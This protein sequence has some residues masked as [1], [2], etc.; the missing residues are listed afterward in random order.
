MKSK[1]KKVI[2]PIF[3]IEN[4]HT[5]RIRYPLLQTAKGVVVV[6]VVEEVVE[7]EEEVLLLLSM[8]LLSG[9]CRR[10]RKEGV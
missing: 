4:S 6:V 1:G 2:S 10:E 5:Q 8:T 3:E 7:E 9:V